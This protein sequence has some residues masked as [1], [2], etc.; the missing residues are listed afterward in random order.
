MGIVNSYRFACQGNVIRKPVRVVL[1][2]LWHQQQS[3]KHQAWL[4]KGRGTQRSHCGH[5][6]CCAVS[7][8]F[9][10]RFQALRVNLMG[11]AVLSWVRMARCILRYHTFLWPLSLY[12]LDIYGENGQS[13]VDSLVSIIPKSNWSKST[14]DPISLPRTDLEKAWKLI[15]SASKIAE[16]CWR[17]GPLDKALCLWDL[18]HLQLP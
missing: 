5:L 10:D 14:M 16:A 11:W 7:Q 4:S 15:L 2:G 9:G 8:L 3:L 17:W 13:E 6:G 18:L 12:G 1:K